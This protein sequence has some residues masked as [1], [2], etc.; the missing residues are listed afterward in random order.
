MKPPAIWVA[1][2]P[3]L[4]G[5]G[6]GKSVYGPATWA[7]GTLPAEIDSDDKI[8]IDGVLYDVEG[9]AGDWQSPFTGWHPGLEVAVK[10]AGAV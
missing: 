1:V 8:L 5:V 2:E 4:I 9:H 6:V 10:R 7:N 3:S